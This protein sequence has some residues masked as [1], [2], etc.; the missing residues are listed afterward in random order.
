MTIYYPDAG[1]KSDTDGNT[2][3]LASAVP[4]ALA[5]WTN[6]TALTSTELAYL[7]DDDTNGVSFE[8]VYSGP[9]DE[10]FYAGGVLVRFTVTDASL[11][12]LDFTLKGDDDGSAC[13]SLYIY[14]A[15]TTAFEEK[16]TYTGSGSPATFTL[17]ASIMTGVDDYRDAS[18]YVYALVALT[19]DAGYSASLNFA[20]CESTADGGASFTPKVIIL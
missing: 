3:V 19:S 17:S 15:T 11:S 14:N 6:E 1:Y 5:D 10:V 12:Q 13:L 4:G 18:N 9:P 8:E 7:D 2:D 20:K 16:D